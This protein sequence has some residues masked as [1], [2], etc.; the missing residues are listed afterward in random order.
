AKTA[1]EANARLTPDLQFVPT[2][3]KKLSGAL[4]ESNF[5]TARAEFVN[6]IPGESDAALFRRRAETLD[7]F[8]KTIDRKV[9]NQQTLD[10][11]KFKGEGAYATD[12]DRAYLEKF[13]SK[14]HT[15]ETYADTLARQMD[16]NPLTAKLRNWTRK[17]I[18]W[19]PLPHAFKNVGT[20]AYLAGGPEVVVKA[21]W[22]MAK[23][24]IGEE[25]VA[26]Q[27]RIGARAFYQRLEQ[28]EPRAGLGGLSDKIY[29]GSANTMQYMEDA[30]RQA[31]L[32]QVD[33]ATPTRTGTVFE[34]DDEFTK[35][36]LVSDKVGDYHNQMGLVRTLE[37]M[38]GPFI[39]FRLGI[40]PRKVMQSI[41]ENPQRA[42][43]IA[44]AQYDINENRKGG[45]KKNEMRI[46]GPVGD[47]SEF[48]YGAGS[49]WDPIASPFMY[50]VN[51]VMPMS[52]APS[53]G[54]FWQQAPSAVLNRTAE[55][56]VRFYSAG[57]DAWRAWSGTA[58][59]GQHMSL[60]D[61]L[62]VQM[63][64]LL[65]IYFHKDQ[66]KWDKQTVKGFK[67]RPI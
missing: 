44:R 35:G 2:K 47:F 52:G 20:L 8:R 50:G 49:M 53:Q 36:A 23:G 16:Q 31:L 22:Y 40:V 5:E 37:A 57:A 3:D 33:R 61:K 29:G 17:A 66:P 28:A 48:L 21:L 18:M 15:G 12:A 34:A 41:R 54:Y 13:G 59:P 63:L 55:N 58:M 6:R 4:R 65:G 11:A 64:G 43:A 56:Y 24:G 19:N 46:G 62:T 32:D 42:L 60:T 7:D 27:M 51:S 9:V 39:A 38:G 67:K 1:G 30:W 45:K 26:R 25:N 14:M 10:A